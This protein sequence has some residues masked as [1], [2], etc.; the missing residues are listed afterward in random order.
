MSVKTY[1][2]VTWRNRIGT[3]VFFRILT[4]ALLF[5]GLCSGLV[6]SDV[7]SLAALLK[8]IVYGL[9]NASYYVLIASGL[10]L[11]FGMMNILNFAHGAIYMMGAFTVFYFFIGVGVNYFPA[12]ILVAIVLAVFGVVVERLIHRPLGGFGQAA[13]VAFLGLNML[14]GSVIY[15]TFGTIQK[16]VPSVFPGVVNI[17]VV[18]VGLERILVI[19][20]A[21]ALLVGLYLLL[22]RTRLG[23]AMRAVSQDWEAAGLQTINVHLIN[24]S[25]FALSFALAGI[26]GAITAPWGVISP[27][28]ADRPLLISFIVI[29][30]GGLGSIRGAIV[31]A[32][33]V[34]LLESIGTVVAGADV[35]YLLLFV[36]I[37]IILI[38]RPGGLFGHA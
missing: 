9:T 38:F 21:V 11:L 23:R 29:I 33:L 24:A 6:L 36:V 17:G 1:G 16:S 32:I 26:A 12:I 20:A 31:G 27:E 2:V 37:F 28:M 10:T 18:T 7:V 34:G 3:G 14:I 22:Y 8:S 15:L 4:V 5:V 13:L 19:P 35:A 30:L 25:A